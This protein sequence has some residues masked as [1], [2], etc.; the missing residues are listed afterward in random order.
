MTDWDDPNDGQIGEETAVADRPTAYI[1]VVRKADV[2]SAPADAP[3]E[4]YALHDENG[5]PL[6]LFSDRAS[7]MALARANSLAPVSVH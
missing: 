3:D 2:A 1:R 7:A 6:A 5:R 4:L